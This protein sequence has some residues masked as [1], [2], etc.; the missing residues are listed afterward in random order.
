MSYPSLRLPPNGVDNRP[1]S[2]GSA[3]SGH[4]LQPGNQDQALPLDLSGSKHP[5]DVFSASDFNITALIASLTDGLIAQS[6]E[7]GGG[8]SIWVTRV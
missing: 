5:L 6:K 2:R 4:V 8:A 7:E 3:S 1:S